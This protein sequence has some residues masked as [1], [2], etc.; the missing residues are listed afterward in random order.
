MIL[1]LVPQGLISLYSLAES[2]F[3][4]KKRLFTHTKSLTTLQKL[5]PKRESIFGG[6]KNPYMWYMW[7]LAHWLSL[8][9][10]RFTLFIKHNWT[11]WMILQEPALCSSFLHF[12]S[13]EMKTKILWSGSIMWI[14]ESF[15]FTEQVSILPFTFIIKRWYYYLSSGSFL[16]DVT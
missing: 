8:L 2:R 9:L 5:L 11:H 14:S 6:Q 4:T 10:L 3:Y 1:F 13:C 7:Y 12:T 15:S 16:W